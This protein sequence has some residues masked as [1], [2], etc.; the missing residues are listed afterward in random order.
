MFRLFIV[1]D[2]RYE[3]LGIKDSIDWSALGIE[4]VGVFANGAE[5]LA[6]ID[7]LKPHIVITDI[8]MPRMNGIEMSE[9]IKQSYPDIKIIFLSCHSD[10]EFARSALDL[11]VYGYVLK[12]IIADELEKALNKLLH[13]FTEEHMQQIEKERM[14]KQL[15]EMMPL[16]REQFL[17]E[18]LLGNFRNRE[19]M[20]KRIAFLRLPIEESANIRVISINL[21]HAGEHAEDRSAM[22]AY[23]ISYTIKS[24]ISAAETDGSRIYP[25]QI[26]EHEFVAI[27]VEPPRV[28]ASYA[29]EAE[30][31]RGAIDA[32]VKI[33]SE[34]V[35]RLKRNMTMGISNGSEQLTELSLLYKQSQRAVRTRFYTGS[36]PIIRFEEIDDRSDIPFEE[37]PSLE[38]VY[39]DM[40]SLLS[41]GSGQDIQEFIDKYLHADGARLGENYVKGFALLFAHLTGILLMEANY[42]IKEVFGDSASVWDKLNRMNTKEDVVQWIQHIF[43]TIKERLTDKNVTKNAKLVGA[44][45]QMI[46]E[47]YRRQIS[48]EDISKSVYLS[49]RHANGLF[50]K[51]T[52]Q[53]IFDYL[54]H[55]RIDTAK[56]LLK[57]EGAK[58]AAVAEAVGYL[59]TSYFILAFK[60]IVGV[61][62]A[63]FKGKATG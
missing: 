32:A 15:D 7:A 12:P 47:N 10:F 28:N 46:H 56:H 20:R 41:F 24:I 43:A 58:V 29:P 9:R 42:A 25:V 30:P 33:Y 3:R 17:K 4:V 53:T 23:F 2:N 38:E 39:Q 16:V 40:K 45:K 61:T 8:A 14:L 36:N 44:I 5:A 55:H 18:V 54:I 52:G 31:E 50:K 62:P 11:G 60:K 48:I 63:E 51:E 1:D 19:E 22:D 6:Q 35:R 13:D 21:Y 59:N 34:I 37:M 57:E 26:S 49:G 27:V